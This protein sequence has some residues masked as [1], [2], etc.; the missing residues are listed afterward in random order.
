MPGEVVAVSIAEIWVVLW[1]TVPLEHVGLGPKLESRL[2]CGILSP[3][4]WGI[5]NPLIR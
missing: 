5:V 1:Y 3:H 2:S 4:L